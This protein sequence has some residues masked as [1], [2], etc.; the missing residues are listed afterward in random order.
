LDEPEGVL[1]TEAVVPRHD[2][3]EVTVGGFFDPSEHA[4]EFVGRPLY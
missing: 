4:F 2:R 1:G 3:R